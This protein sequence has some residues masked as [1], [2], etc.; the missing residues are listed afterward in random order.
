[1]VVP[2]HDEQA[3][4]AACL[5][6]IRLSASRAGDVAVQIVVVAD[7]CR[8]DTAAIAAASGAEVVEIDARN[9]GLARDRGFRHALKAGSRGLWLATTDADTVVG[10]DWLPW[11]RGHALRR[12][13]LLAGTVVVA[14]WSD[15]PA[16][17]RREYDKLYVSTHGHV[18]GANLGC[19]AQ[20]YQDIGGFAA[21]THDE[22]QD[23][24]ARA[25]KAG[26]TVRY[27]PDCPVVTSSRRAGRAPHGFA[28][29]LTAVAAGLS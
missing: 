6:S 16:T 18:H 1:M 15:W 21:L 26:K 8:D 23:L 14:D 11:H 17:V 12:T 9:V 27:D 10:A 24:V 29:H 5:A 19:D 3:T 28:A 22:D 2:A 13:E 25:L 20:S 4:I 7:G